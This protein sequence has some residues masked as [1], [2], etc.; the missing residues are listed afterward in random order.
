[1]YKLFFLYP[2]NIS[3]NTGCRKEEP[4]VQQEEI[5]YKIESIDDIRVK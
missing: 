4:A 5:S 1:M 3:P 2:D